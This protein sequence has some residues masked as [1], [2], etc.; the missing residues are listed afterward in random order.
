ML[1]PDVLAL[2]NWIEDPIPSG[3]G[4]EERHVQHQHW[5]VPIPALAKPISRPFDF[6]C[7]QVC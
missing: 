7:F 5:I 1:T 3:T 2:R 6:A 4:I